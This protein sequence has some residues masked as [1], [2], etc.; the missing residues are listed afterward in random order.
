MEREDLYN[1]EAEKTKGGHRKKKL[2]LLFCVL[3]IFGLA[4]SARLQ[5]RSSDGI[6][7]KVRRMIKIAFSGGD[8]TH[9]IPDVFSGLESINSEDHSRCHLRWVAN[10]YGSK[11]TVAMDRAST[12]SKLQVLAL[13]C[14]GAMSTGTVTLTALDQD[15]LTSVLP[16]N[17]SC[18]LKYNV[19]SQAIESANTEIHSVIYTITDIF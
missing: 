3:L 13:N 6:T 18:D 4:E 12:K 11:I 10:Q 5:N 19:A 16:S 1:L 7:I 15:F 17:G 2:T 9:T 14:T 8:I